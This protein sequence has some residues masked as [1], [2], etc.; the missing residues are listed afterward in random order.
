MRLDGPAIIEERE[1]TTVVGP[2]ATVEVDEFRN[3][4]ITL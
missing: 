4:H 2:R 3:L 1:S